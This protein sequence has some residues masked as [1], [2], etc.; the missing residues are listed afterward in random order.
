MILSILGDLN[1]LTGLCW[2]AMVGK[3]QAL[4]EWPCQPPE[5]HCMYNWY[6]GVENE[7]C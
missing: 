7:M 1:A 5:Y 6:T 2:W 4:A 3:Q